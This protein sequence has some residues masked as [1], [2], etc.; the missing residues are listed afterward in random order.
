MDDWTHILD[1]RTRKHVHFARAYAEHFAH[2]A[3]GHMDLMTIA[4]LAQCIE[5]LL[6][7]GAIDKEPS[8]STDLLTPAEKV[9][10]DPTRPPTGRKPGGFA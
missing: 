2:G 1:D 7:R 5:N 8:R 6:Y 9:E 3:P 10:I 4:R